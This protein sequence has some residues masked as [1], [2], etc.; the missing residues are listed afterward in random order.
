MSAHQ[1][2]LDAAKIQLMTHPDSIFITSVC[3]SMKHIW[4]DKIPTACTNGVYIKY[5]PQFWLDLDPDEQLFLLLHETWH[6]AFAHMGRLQGRDSRRWNKAADYVIN[7][8]LVKAG[9]KMPKGGLYDAKYAGMSTEE[10]Y[11][12]LEDDPTSNL[13]MDDLVPS[14]GTL[15][16]ADQAQKDLDD[17]L[18]RARMQSEMAEGFSSVPGEIQLY[19]NGLL[20]PKLPW[21]R[22]L[23]R[24]AARAVKT[25]R[26]F[27]RPNR[28]FFPKIL[29]PSRFST[30]LTDIAIAGDISGS[31]T[32]ITFKQYL[33]EAYYVLVK[34]KPSSLKFMQF[35]TI[36]KNVAE[37][38]NINDLMDVTVHGRGGTNINPVIQWANEHRPS[39]MVILTDGQFH[40]TEPNPKVPIIWAISDNPGFNPP[41]GKV[42]HL[43]K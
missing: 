20:D 36:I 4:D 7:Y 9:Y 28:R 32:D 33:S 26:S 38:D 41:Y 34:C 10:V 43:P 6:V 2:Q 19:I 24:F 17:I 37:I 18:V 12:L 30:G 3:F 15:E 11:A 42:V 8:M 39:V 31:V 1:K 14:D 29:L 5:N 22:I 21:T 27:K 35:D 25:G 16:E 40:L 13:P 23:Q